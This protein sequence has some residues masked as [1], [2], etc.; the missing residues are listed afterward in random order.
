MDKSWI[1]E[2]DRV[3]TKY[4]DGV[5]KFIE[6][7]AIN[8]PSSDGKISCPCVKCANGHR[9]SKEAVL[10]HILEHGFSISYTHWFCHG[11]QLSA[12]DGV[13]SAPDIVDYG[14]QANQNVR[15]FIQDI[16]SGHDHLRQG[17]NQT[18]PSGEHLDDATRFVKILRETDEPLFEGC[19]K[20]SKLSFILDL[21]HK[22]CMN[23]WSNKSFN[24]LLSTLRETLPEGEQLP[25]SSYEVKKLIGD[26]GLGYEKIHACP[27][28][29]MLF[30][31][32]MANLN[33]CSV[34]GASRWFEEGNS[35]EVGPS[36]TKKR[37]KLKPRKVLRWF[38]LK[39]RLQR[40]FMCSK[41]AHLMRWH[42]DERIDDGILRHPADARAWKHFD[43]THI[44]FSQDPRNVRIGLCSDG[45]NPFRSMNVNHSTW[46]VVLC[47]YNFP[48]WLCMKQPSF[49]LSLLIAGP[50]SP[51]NKI[52]VFLQP[53]IDELID[54]WVNGCITYD[55]HSKTT[56]HMRAALLWTI[57]DFPAYNML[58]G[59]NTK[60]RFACPCCGFDTYSDWSNE[61]GKYCFL[62]HRR[63]LWPEHPY[64]RDRRNFNGKPEW[65]EAPTMLTGD[66]ALAQLSG[67]Q[68]VHDKDGN[69]VPSTEGW[70]KRSI[71]WSLPYWSTNL[72]RHNLD[73]MH[74]EKNVCD[75][76]V[77][78][79]LN[80]EGKSKDNL[81]SRLDLQRLGI[82]RELHPQELP[83]GKFLLPPA[84]YT[85]SNGEKDQMLQV[86]KSVKVSDSYASNISRCVKLKQRKLTGLKTHDCHVLLHD[87]LPIAIR[88]VVKDNVAQVI[89]ELCIYF[90]EICSKALSVTYLTKLESQI[91]ETL[92]RMEM[93]FPPSFFTVMVH[94]T[95][96]LATEAK[97]AGPVN[98]RWMFPF[99]RYSQDLYSTMFTVISKT[100]STLN[101]T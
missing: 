71:F 57:N 52:D 28:N 66:D 60:K 91:G 82:R 100:L 30:W 11:E 24:N 44:N 86:L 54:L 83:N 61:C 90:K 39:P 17:G 43:A 64:R 81:K 65:A 37:K 49:I 5:T 97:L 4:L 53:L 98:Y 77:G 26:L 21:F 31:K 47:V 32:D 94:L 45:F 101:F 58:S 96:H 29:C 87:L 50:E 12:D 35:S 67:E 34:C 1:Y 22:K 3:S 46:P 15:Q 38:P 18:D 20:H 69:N 41:T 10:E 93:I 9:A 80:M 72:I 27:N 8:S 51:S 55:A 78:T 23:G 85:M 19:K 36:R 73:V 42:Y 95:V 48:P 16:A 7:A 74:I 59:W 40:F 68:R 13:G 6:F 89:N 76:I 2:E 25:R 92:S 63:F 84:C 99:E 62:G 79:L 70:S 14:S 88:G 75:N 33:N 56:F